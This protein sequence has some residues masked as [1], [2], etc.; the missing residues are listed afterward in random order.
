MAERK[1]VFSFIVLALKKNPNGKSVLFKPPLM[2]TTTY[3]MRYA[4]CMEIF[5]VR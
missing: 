3:G 1:S 4:V 2:T 5:S